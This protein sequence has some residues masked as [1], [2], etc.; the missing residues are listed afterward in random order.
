[1]RRMIEG[2]TFLVEPVTSWTVQESCTFRHWV[3][4]V[5]QSI[6]ISMAGVIFTWTAAGGTPARRDSESNARWRNVGGSFID[7]TACSETGDAGFAQGIAVGD[8]NE[9]GFPDL[10]VLNYGPTRC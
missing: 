8:V 6:S 3:A 2:F 7:V 10:L 1:M 5:V 9:D 4:A